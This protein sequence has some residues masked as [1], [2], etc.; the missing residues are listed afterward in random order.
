MIFLLWLTKV[1]GF[2]MC[3]AILVSVVLGTLWTSAGSLSQN[4]G[5]EASVSYHVGAG[6]RT[7][8]FCKS[9]KCP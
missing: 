6:N 5:G 4:S 7:Q 3:T 9:C 2:Q 8:G 1:M